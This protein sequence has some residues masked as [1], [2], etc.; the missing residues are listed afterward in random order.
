VNSA[1]TPPRF[2]AI[3]M[4]RRLGNIPI[5]DPIRLAAMYEARARD[6]LAQSTWHGEGQNPAAGEIFRSAYEIDMQ[7]AKAV[8]AA[9]A[10][11]PE[12]A[13]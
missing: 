5:G 6:C 10:K 7:K 13:A 9:A 12:D 4:L 2:P 3:K 1:A 8:L 11:E